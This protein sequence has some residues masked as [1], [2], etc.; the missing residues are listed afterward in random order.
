[1]SQ[2]EAAET[3]ALSR[4][5]TKEIGVEAV[6]RVTGALLSPEGLDALADLLQLSLHSLAIRVGEA[7]SQEADA[8]LGFMLTPRFELALADYAHRLAA[9]VAIEN[10][11]ALA[12]SLGEGLAA[13]EEETALIARIAQVFGQ[14][15]GGKALT[16]SGREATY[17][18]GM[19]ALEA[20]KLAGYSEK[21]WLAAQD[22]PGQGV[23]AE[24]DGQVI[25]IEAEFV[26]DDGSR[27][28]HPGALAKLAVEDPEDAE[29]SD[30]QDPDMPLSEAPMED[31]L[32]PAPAPQLEASMAEWADC[33]CALIAPLL[34]SEGAEA[35]GVD[36]GDT[37]EP[38]AEM[39]E[40]EGRND[41]SAGE[42]EADRRP[43]RS[44]EARL[45]LWH[46]REALRQG[47]ADELEDAF[48]LLFAQQEATA[49]EALE[50][51]L[52]EAE[53]ATGQAEAGEG[54]LAG[55]AGPA[56]SAGQESQS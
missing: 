37:S 25:P 22:G 53:Q 19:A 23:H 6:Q 50:A 49:L 46:R 47:L 21:E 48:L 9:G 14:T 7:V 4:L 55:Q 31:P 26:A 29:P 39:T 15:A 51:A 3:R 2:D 13:G 41:E 34:P 33:R 1:M 8:I 17:L 24:L 52:A 5:E 38:G 20:L 42:A 16:M 44:P 56:N 45:S 11:F 35:T 30:D 43:V 36:M 28:P 27:G 10:Q 32:E 54:T 18:A 12:D 40:A